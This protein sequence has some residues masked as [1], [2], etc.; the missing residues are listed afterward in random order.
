MAQVLTRLNL[1]S[2]AFPFLSEFSGRGII[3]KQS[4][5]NYVP[6]TV[7]KEDLDKDIGIPQIF[8]CHNIMATGQGYMSVSYVRTANK[9]SVGFTKFKD[10]IPVI[11][12]AGHKIY[13]GWDSDGKLYKTTSPLFSVWTQFQ[14]IAAFGNKEITYCVVSGKT[15]IYVA[16]TGCY[17]FD[18]AGTNTLSAQTLTGITP[19]AVSGILA[20][21]GYMLTYSTNAIL[22]SSLIDPTDFTPSLTTGAGGGSVQNVR[23]D[24]VAVVPH[25]TGFVVYT[26]QNAVAASAS[27]N[28]RYPFNFRELVASGGV[29]SKNLI[30]Y[31]ANTGSH[32]VYT[33]SGLQLISLQQSQTTLPELT[34]FIAGSVF[35]DF[36]ENTQRLEITHLSVPMKKRLAL[37]ADRYLVVS[38]GITS[39]THALIYDIVTKRWSKLKI[40]HLVCFE[41]SL[42]QAETYT[43]SPRRSM[44]FLQED[45]TIYTA[46]FD[47][48]DLTSDGVLLL[49]KIQYIRQRVT[50]LYSVD[51]ENVQPGANFDLQDWYTLDGKS[52]RVASGYCTDTAAQTRKYLFNQVGVNHSLLFLG[53]F[54]LVSIV[55]STGVHGRR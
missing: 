45:G 24:I 44:A 6:S 26:N 54:N 28:T 36:N 55:S 37:I 53:C 20:C 50:S 23:G 4:D 14:T 3:V 10:I 31:D 51:V 19:T 15:Y 9:I 35:E 42:L 16:N 49:G 30:T 5:Q 7:S 25:T 8:Y 18:F 11:D 13:L 40:P 41:F 46:R 29:F 1:A 2:T 47:T 27:N 33:T 38:Y 39:L 48:R 52:M 32:Y 22:W 12:D 17:I 43:E 21:Q 34:D